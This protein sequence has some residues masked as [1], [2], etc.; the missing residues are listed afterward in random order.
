MMHESKINANG[1]FASN[2]EPNL[3]MADYIYLCMEAPDTE[4]LLDAM[5]RLRAFMATSELPDTAERIKGAEE[6]VRRSP[7]N[8]KIVHDMVCCWLIQMQR[9]LLQDLVDGEYTGD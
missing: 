8:D 4:G 9:K 7:K 2:H 3:C 1:K 5:E 6:I